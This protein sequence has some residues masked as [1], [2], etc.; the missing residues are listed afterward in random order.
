MAGWIQRVSA[1]F[2]ARGPA[3][4]AAALHQPAVLRSVKPTPRRIVLPPIPATVLPA[5]LPA[6]AAIEEGAATV[7]QQRPFIEWLLDTGPTLDIPIRIPEL[8]LLGRLDAVLA[9]DKSRGELLPRARAVIPQLLNSLRDESQTVETLADRVA[10]DPHLVTEVLRLANSSVSQGAEPVGDLP[11]A[12]HRVGTDG[13]RR[14]IAS[15]VLKPMFHAQADAL[16]ARAEPKLWA[17]SEAKAA[18]CM[19]LATV[20][21]LDPFEGYLAGLMH[22][23]GWTAALR[24]IDRSGSKPA[25]PF[26]REF[27]DAFDA[28]REMF[29]ALLMMHWQLSDALTALAAEML[30]VGLRATA[31]P[32][33]Q[34]L[35]AA[36]Q[37]ASMRMLEESAATQPIER[38]KTPR[39][40]PRVA[41]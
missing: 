2:G 6:V 30:E 5:V 24:A 37:H 25:M 23:V 4:L 3:P 11:Q 15:V 31:S 8:H 14:V 18:E 35:L 13:L 16:S 33:G 22:D 32:L 29:F 20:A 7:V 41:A 19:R 40:A 36:D 26:S 1:I 38:R 27:I 34:A 10:R 9:S 21:G 12:I 28:R 39:P 17:H